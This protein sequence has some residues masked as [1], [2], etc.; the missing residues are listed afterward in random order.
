MLKS[1]NLTS[2]PGD[3]KRLKRSRRQAK[4]NKKEAR[5]RR[6]NLRRKH[7]QNGLWIKGFFKRLLS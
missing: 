1:D 2:D 7:D 4:Q 6:Q 5:T 3:E